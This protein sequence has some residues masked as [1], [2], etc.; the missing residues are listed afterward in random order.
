[1][2]WKRALR[3]PDHNFSGNRESGRRKRPQ[4]LARAEQNA[5]Q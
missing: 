2:R 3:E 4:G 5:K 1:M